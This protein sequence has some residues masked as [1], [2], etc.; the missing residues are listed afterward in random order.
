MYGNQVFISYIGL[1]FIYSLNII[2]M[3]ERVIW[4]QHV[5]DKIIIQVTARAHR[6]KVFTN[7]WK[8]SAIVNNS[9]SL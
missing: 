6:T 4:M 2:K 1:L 7:T 9:T 5:I 3:L 8:N